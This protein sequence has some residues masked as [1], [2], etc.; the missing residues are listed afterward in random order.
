MKD[1]MALAEIKE[2]AKSCW[3]CEPPEKMN[4]SWWHCCSKWTFEVDQHIDM[5]FGSTAKENSKWCEA[6]ERSEYPLDLDE[7]CMLVSKDGIKWTCEAY[8][9]LPG[10][11]GAPSAFI[12][13]D[14]LEAFK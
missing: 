6:K 7:A 4:D 8:S 5:P 13:W 12:K 9:I 3:K 10:C 2:Y 1:K 14:E 11:Y